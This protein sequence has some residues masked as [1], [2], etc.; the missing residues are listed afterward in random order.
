MRTARKAAI[1]ASCK[2]SACRPRRREQRRRFYHP[3]TPCTMP[4][5]AHEGE[6]T[7][8]RSAPAHRKSGVSGARSGG[9]R[10]GDPFRIQGPP[11]TVLA[12]VKRF[13]GNKGLAAVR[14]L[15]KRQGATNPPSKSESGRA[16]SLHNA[17]AVTFGMLFGAVSRRRRILR[18][19][20]RARGNQKPRSRLSPHG[21]IPMSPTANVAAMGVAF[22]RHGLPSPP[23]MAATRPRISLYWEAKPSAR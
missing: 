5:G 6:T 7:G 19:G 21:I 13:G 9:T 10:S 8:R 23:R 3:R 17:K 15:R 14:D 16:K 11:V 22:H 1:A 4:E 12:A 2:V 18:L 20:Y